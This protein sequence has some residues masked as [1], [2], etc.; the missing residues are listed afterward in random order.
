[1]TEP[2]APMSTAV[3][4]KPPF[5]RDVAIQIGVSSAPVITTNAHHT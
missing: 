3:N 1:M 2:N 4:P 5:S